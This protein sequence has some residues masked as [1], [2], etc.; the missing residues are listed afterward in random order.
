MMIEVFK[1]NVESSIQAKYLQVLIQQ[2][3]FFTEVNFDLED[4][5]KVLRVKGE[6][7]CTLN[8]ILLM[9]ANGYECNVLE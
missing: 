4:C 8:I 3:F 6:K 7:I 9:A 1:T 2:H 5:D